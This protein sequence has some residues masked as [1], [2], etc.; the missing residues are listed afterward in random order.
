MASDT[1]S[2]PGA[3]LASIGSWRPP[4]PGRLATI[5]HDRA[6]VRRL[7]NSD[8]LSDIPRGRL[9]YD[10]AEDRGASNAEN[11]YAVDKDDLDAENVPVMG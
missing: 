7:P 8:S 1:H 9:V 10:S 3:L 11:D 4:G 6:V 5:V 2:I